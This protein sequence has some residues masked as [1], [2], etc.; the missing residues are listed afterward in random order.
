MAARTNWAWLPVGLVLGVTPFAAQAQSATQGSASAQPAMPKPMPELTMPGSVPSDAARKKR[1]AH[2]ATSRNS[3]HRSHAQ[4]RG[5]VAI[6]DRPKLAN[7]ELLEPLP[8]P[9]QPP[10]VTVPVPAYSFENFVTNYTTP[11][12]PV[13]CHPARHDRFNPDPRLIDEI[14]VL[15]TADNP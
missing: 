14:P 7:V 4:S 15:C 8:H 2:T 13:I 3:H 5:N 9:P 11:P 1:Y 12:P 10:H 6:R